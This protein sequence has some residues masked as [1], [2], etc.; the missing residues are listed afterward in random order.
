MPP[1]SDKDRAASISSGTS[2]YA[3]T[4]ESFSSFKREF[5]PELKVSRL[6][7]MSDLSVYPLNSC[8]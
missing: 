5:I 6:S 7:G 8:I 1:V 2:M 4:I 3:M